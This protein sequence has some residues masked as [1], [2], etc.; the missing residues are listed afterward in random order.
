M[1]GNQSGIVT[2]SS[3]SNEGLTV[4][5]SIVNYNTTLG[6]S[7][8]NRGDS[9]YNCQI[10]NNLVGIFDNNQDNT[11]PTQI[12]KNTIMNNGIGLQI[13]GTSDNIYCNKICNNTTYDLKY[14][15]VSNISLINNYWCT[16]DSAAT[17]AVIYDGYDN[18]TYGLVRFMPMD[19]TCNFTTGIKMYETQHF[20]FNVFPNPTSTNLNLELPAG[21]TKATCILYNLL[22]EVL[23]YT[24]TER[25]LTP[26]DVS[27]LAAGIYII[28]TTS[29][30]NSYKQKWIKQ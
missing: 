11:Y 14:T 28:Q 26:I 5:N 12:T 10:E 15:G 27:S 3:V 21:I 24:D 20:S 9:V 13:P 18:V 6:I 1:K 2:G 22:G 23:Y 29:G 30:G 16:A 8:S 7:I 4:K 19:T 17:E 25:Q